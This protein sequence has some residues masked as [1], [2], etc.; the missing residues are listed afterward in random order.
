MPAI[1]V[2]RAWACRHGSVHGSRVHGSFHTSTSTGQARS[3]PQQRLQRARVSARPQ[4]PA[5]ALFFDGAHCRPPSHVP[6]GTLPR[7][8]VLQI[9]CFLFL[10]SIPSISVRFYHPSLPRSSCTCLDIALVQL[11]VDSSADLDPFGKPPG[12]ATDRTLKDTNGLPHCYRCATSHSPVD[13][14]YIS[15]SKPGTLQNPFDIINNITSRSLQTA[16]LVFRT[17]ADNFD[18]C[19]RAEQQTA[20]RPSPLTIIGRILRSP[21]HH[22]AN[23]AQRHRVRPVTCIRPCHSPTRGSLPPLGQSLPAQASLPVLV[24]VDLLYA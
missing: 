9:C 13:E 20:R 10:S 3:R 14:R 12:R 18:R 5:P 21:A 19:S 17:E 4:P 6:N 22:I 2:C 23:C 1:I 15:T 16:T 24:I 11:A 8:S 7:L